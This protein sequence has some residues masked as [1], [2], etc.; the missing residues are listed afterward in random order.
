MTTGSALTGSLTFTTDADT[1]ITGSW[2]LTYQAISDSSSSAA[3]VSGSYQ[4][5][6]TGDVISISSG[7][8]ISGTNASDGCT[9]SGSIAT[10][11]STHNIYEIAYTY[12]NCTGSYQSLNGVQFTGLA[13]F[14]TG[15]SP[16]QL[17]LGVSGSSDSNKYGL[18]AAWNAST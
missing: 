3:T 8:A 10:S 16:A 13:T 11:D 14:N 18:V 15:T 12:S 1:A 17:V 6:V 2:P 9:L 5:A 7:G 4:D